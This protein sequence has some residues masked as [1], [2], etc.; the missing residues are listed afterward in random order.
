M[1]DLQQAIDDDRRE[2]ER[3]MAR[4]IRE[5]GLPSWIAAERARHIIRNRRLSRY[6]YYVGCRHD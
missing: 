3:E 2:I 4:L 1:N 6:G 5:Q